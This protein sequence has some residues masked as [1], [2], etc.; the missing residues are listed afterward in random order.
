[1]NISLKC[2][3]AALLV[4]SPLM[5]SAVEEHHPDQTST[6]PA[7]TSEAATPMQ[8]KAMTEQIQK[9]Q[10]AHDR[11]VAA[12]TPSERQTAMQENMK[13][14]KDSMGMVQKNCNGMGMSGNKDGMG[15]MNMPMSK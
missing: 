4:S 10:A 3:L 13:M 1:M 7:Q 15:M 12:K 2:I 11:A 8:N 9:M 6:T 14:M 5:V